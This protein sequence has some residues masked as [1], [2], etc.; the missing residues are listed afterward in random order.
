MKKL[1]FAA[2][3]GAALM[4]FYD[5]ANGTQRRDA[6]Q[7]KFNRGT[8][9]IPAEPPAPVTSL[10]ADRIDVARVASR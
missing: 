5:P 6:M 10:G 7:R 9:G 8:P 3:V 1:M 2:A 4:W